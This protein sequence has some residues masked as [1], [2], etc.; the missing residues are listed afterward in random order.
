MTRFKEL[1]RI[2]T[3]IQH[4]NR[5]E[6]EWAV[7]YCKMRTQLAQ[8]KDHKKYWLGVERKVRIALSDIAGWRE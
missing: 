6:L 4:H 7:G 8:Q 1:R 5:T 3:A 2:E